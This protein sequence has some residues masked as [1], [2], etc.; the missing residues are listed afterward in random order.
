MN[1]FETEVVWQRGKECRVRARENPALT[2]APPPDFGG[3]EPA[4]ETALLQ[5]RRKD[6]CPGS[7][8]RLL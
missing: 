8:E 2:V 4:E 6:G 1:V 3:P 7:A 5:R